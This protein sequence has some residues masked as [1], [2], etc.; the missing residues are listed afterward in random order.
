MNY[1]SALFCPWLVFFYIR[2]TKRGFICLL[3]QITVVGWMPVTV[4]SFF[5]MASY[6]KKKESE[7]ILDAINASR[8]K[9]GY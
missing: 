8:R 3:L 7:R 5:T 4:W 6:N 9:R 1:L 2:E